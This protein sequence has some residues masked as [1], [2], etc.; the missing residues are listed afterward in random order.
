[1]TGHSEYEPLCLRD[2][3]VR[4]LAAGINPSIPENYFPDD[5]PEVEPVVTWRS[6]GNLMFSNWLNYYVY[7]SP[8]TRRSIGRGLARS[9]LI[10]ALTTV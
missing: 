1:M 7:T 4:D 3:Y 10:W 6:H 2:E 5:N 9:S 8:Q